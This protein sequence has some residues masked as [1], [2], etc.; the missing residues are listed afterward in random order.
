MAPRIPS[1][2]APALRAV[3][4]FMFL[5]ASAQAVDEALLVGVSQYPTLGEE[6][7]L[8]GP[9]NDVLL[10]QEVLVQRGLDP[11]HVRILADGVTGA[12]LPT[13]AAI[14]GALDDLANRL[15]EG[16][17][18]YL[19]LSGHASRQPNG[20]D[21]DDE[22]DGLDEVFLPRDI[23]RWEA[24]GGRI[25]NGIVD[26]ELGLLIDRLVAKGAFVWLVADTCTSETI[27]RGAPPTQVHY[28]GIAA[29]ALGVPTAPGG[30]DGS[31]QS[32]DTWQAGSFNVEVSASTVAARGGGNQGVG[33]AGGYVAFYAARAGEP[34]PEEKLPDHAA[35]ARWYGLLTRRLAEALAAT[36]QAGRATSYRRLGERIRQGYAGRQAPN[37]LFDGPGLD[38]PV[39]GSATQGTV[40]RALQWPIIKKTYP[41]G[42]H[43]PV[44]RLAQ[45]GPGSRLALLAK[46]DDATAQALG[47]A[48]VGS[49][50]D[51]SAELRTIAADGKPALETGAIP[52]DAYARLVHQAIDFEVRV[53]RP[54][55][56]ADANAAERAAAGLIE[57][58]ASQPTAEGI[59][60]RWVAPGEAAEIRLGFTPRDS[61]L[62]RS[63]HGTADKHTALLW[64]AQGD[65]GIRYDGPAGNISIELGGTPVEFEA[66]LRD[67]LQRIAK[68]L[69]LNRVAER[70]ASASA[71]GK[72]KV[73]LRI[74][75]KGSDEDCDRGAEPLTPDGIATPAIGDRA[76]L[77]I[78]NLG[79]APLDINIFFVD[80]RYGIH[81]VHPSGEQPSMM[82]DPGQSMARIRKRFE[83]DTLGQEQLIVIAVEHGQQGQPLD[84]GFLAQPTLPP[85][86]SG[87][88]RAADGSGLIGLVEAAGFGVGGTRGALDPLDRRASVA[89][90]RWR[91]HGTVPAVLLNSGG[92]RR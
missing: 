29:S 52:A 44:G 57:R 10:M 23:T 58:L 7:Q 84:L 32:L 48:E 92:G 39:L 46:P 62:C 27:V 60:L 5:A 67:T 90:Y 1:R 13:R 50:Q 28:R 81:P 37:P 88:T 61:A 41:A 51:L 80:G 8:R 31:G 59:R 66:K 43:I 38:A 25:E 6:H 15:G 55:L 78:K 56:P 9:R 24:K 75:P 20:P 18:L 22:P 21:G 65:G 86:R 85:T 2:A 3:L 11:A 14:L 77:D 33:S 4:P 49:A 72:L 69:N 26:D 76:C 82:L 47:I 64:V 30:A 54:A 71:D 40:E 79:E 68:V 91:L 34:E 74:R 19:H 42:L 73:D 12:G 87:E 35:D 83:A 36:H 89:I 17:R 63:G 53:A 16:D 45:I 70:L